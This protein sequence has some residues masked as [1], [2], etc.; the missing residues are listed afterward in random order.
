MPKLTYKG[1]RTYKEK[2]A[3][4]K[5]M[6]YT[7]ITRKKEKKDVKVDQMLD[8]QQAKQASKSPKSG[9]KNRSR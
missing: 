6:R 2:A 5:L 3:E 7:K 1:H 4:P 8:M 9:G